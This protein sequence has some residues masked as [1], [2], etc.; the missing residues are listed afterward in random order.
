MRSRLSGELK[1]RAEKLWPYVRS[2]TSIKLYEQW[3]D[4]FS[5]AFSPEHEMFY[6]ETLLLSVLDVFVLEDTLNVDM[7]HYEWDLGRDRQ[8]LRV[9]CLKIKALYRDSRLQQ[10]FKV[11]EKLRREVIKSIS[12]TRQGLKK[13]QHVR[14][15]DLLIYSTLR[16]HLCERKR[17]DDIAQITRQRYENLIAHI[18]VQCKAYSEDIKRCSRCKSANY[19]SRR[20]QNKHY[21]L[22]KKE[23]KPAEPHASSSGLSAQ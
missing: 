13:I 18:C 22:H 1:Y 19:C 14:F 9:P 8:I 16:V 3:L 11:D 17:R 5:Y 6:W 15:S 10:F 4:C 20:C 7:E 2:L 21:P 12:D 23:C